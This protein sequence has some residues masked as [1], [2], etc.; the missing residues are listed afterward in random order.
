MP[1]KRKLTTNVRRGKPQN[2]TPECQQ[3][4]RR[5]V[6]TAGYI[7]QSLGAGRV[8]GQIFAHLYFSQDAH[9][10]DD[11]TRTLGVSKGSASM[12]VRQLEQWGALEKVW[13]QGDRKDYYR[14]REAL[15]G[16][17]RNAV[18]DLAGKR[19]ESS[20]GLLKA[21]ATD[22]STRKS[23]GSERTEEEQFIMERIQ[24]L[25]DFHTKAQTLWNGVFMNILHH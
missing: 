11:I 16:V 10:L 19:I 5:M 7:T 3:L 1:I 6:E 17:L 20:A 12:C 21:A 14:A 13:V 15:G 2:A 25:Q 8:H 24:K 4:L 9:S 23:S 22:F 18:A